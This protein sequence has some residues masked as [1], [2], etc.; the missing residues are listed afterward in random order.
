ME[1]M[2]SG[3]GNPAMPIFNSR[4]FGNQM[5]LTRSG[6]MPSGYN[7]MPVQQNAVRSQQAGAPAQT[8][9][10]GYSQMYGGQP[11]QQGFSGYAGAA[12]APNS[13]FSG[14]D[15]RA[16]MSSLTGP[17]QA[18]AAMPSLDYNS[19]VMPN[20]GQMQRSNVGI[21]PTKPA[22]Y[23]PQPMPPQRQLPPG[24]YMPPGQG[25]YQ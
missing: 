10:G 3:S 24:I 22:A 1:Q 2:F 19:P 4:G 9:F 12:G 18:G 17:S 23:N 5:P 14:Y 15:P 20:F 25:Y 8:G 21:A 6:A 13:G 7:T 16:A 11:Y